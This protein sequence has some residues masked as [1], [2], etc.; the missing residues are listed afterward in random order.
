MWEA[1]WELSILS[2]Q[3]FGIS[4]GALKNTLYKFKKVLLRLKSVTKS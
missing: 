1:E 3:F 4:T 2:S